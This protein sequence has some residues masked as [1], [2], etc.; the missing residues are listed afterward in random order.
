MNTESITAIIIALVAAIP[1][2]ILAYASLR[3]GQDIEKKAEK[4]DVKL[5]EIHT[6]TNANLARATERIALLEASINKLIGNGSLTKAE[7]KKAKA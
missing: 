4:A 5:D 1:P 6:L 3:K 2:S 7:I